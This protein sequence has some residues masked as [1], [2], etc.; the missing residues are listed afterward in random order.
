MCSR[1]THFAGNT[2]LPLCKHGVCV[3]KH[4]STCSTYRLDTSL[5]LLQSGASLVPRP[6]ESEVHVVCER[7]GDEVGLWP[8]LEPDARNEE[9]RRGLWPIL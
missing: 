7:D 2:C 8:E 6:P 4:H 9:E 1:I 5:A 3:C